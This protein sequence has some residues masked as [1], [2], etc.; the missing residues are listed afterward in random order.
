M[1]KLFFMI[2]AIYVGISFMGCARRPSTRISIEVPNIVNVKIKNTEEF[3]ITDSKLTPYETINN[4]AGVTMI[5]KKGT[6]SPTKLTVAFE[7]NSNSH[8]IYGEY[9]C[10]EKKINSRW[11]QAPVTIDGNY[12]FNTIGYNLD[13]GDSDERVV[14]WN[15]L[16]GSLETGEYRIVKDMLDFRGSGD[17]DTYYLNAEFTIY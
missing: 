14:D 4:F 17:Y 8:C 3:D 13:S 16:Y 9:F 6:E 11:Y 2:F 7:N 12:A 5:V 1:K 15:W 10:L